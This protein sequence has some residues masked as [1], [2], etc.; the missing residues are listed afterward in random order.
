MH[1]FANLLY[2]LSIL[3]VHGKKRSR[4]PVQEATSAQPPCSSM[5]RLLSAAPRHAL[6]PCVRLLPPR[7]IYA[8]AWRGT[9][10]NSCPRP[11]HP[12]P[13]PAAATS[14]SATGPSPAPCPHACHRPMVK[15]VNGEEGNKEDDKRVWHVILYQNGFE[16]FVLRA[17]AR[18]QPKIALKSKGSP[19]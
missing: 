3:Q 6:S 19:K 11:R 1:Q 12:P 7:H 10:R 18:V 14:S 17:M 9:L 15:L 4:R 5:S 13:L 16:G 8:A 2:L